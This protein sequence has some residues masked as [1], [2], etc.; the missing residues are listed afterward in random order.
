[1]HT[2]STSTRWHFT[3]VLCCHSNETRSPIANAPN[4][5]QSAQQC[6]TREHPLP[7]PPSYI[8]VS[9]VLWACSDSQTNTHRQTDRQT[10]TQMHVTNIHFTSSTTRAKCNKTQ[11]Y[12]ITSDEFRRGCFTT[13]VMLNGVFVRLSACCTTSPNTQAVFAVI[14]PHTK[15][16]LWVHIIQTL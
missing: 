14:N 16:R 2:A 15:S 9:A 8:R 10:D 1:M 6:T 3:F 4:S 7:F 12:I 11:C 13:R 5:A